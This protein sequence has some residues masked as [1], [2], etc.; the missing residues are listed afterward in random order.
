MY[1]RVISRRNALTRGHSIETSQSMTLPY[2]NTICPH[3]YNILIHNTYP[4]THSL[5]NDTVTA[6]HSAHAQ[7][8]TGR[9]THSLDGVMTHLALSSICLAN[10][11]LSWGC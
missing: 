8:H 6:T 1:N 9:V 2:G 10:E 5:Q 3:Q 11:D 4:H 7:I